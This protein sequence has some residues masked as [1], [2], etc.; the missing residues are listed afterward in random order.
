MRLNKSL[1][2]HCIKICPDCGLIGERLINRCQECETEYQRREAL[3]Q[4]REAEQRKINKRRA[5]SFDAG[6]D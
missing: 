5:N 1:E 4:R 3:C 2:V 6:W